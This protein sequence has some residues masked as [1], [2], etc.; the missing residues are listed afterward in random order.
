MAAIRAMDNE[1]SSSYLVIELSDGQQKRCPLTTDPCKAISELAIAKD[2]ILSITAKGKCS[3]E[4]CIFIN[5]ADYTQLEKLYFPQLES[6]GNIILGNTK[7][8]DLIGFPQ[9]KTM[10][11]LSVENCP[12][13][14]EISGFPQ[15]ETISYL[16]LENCPAL[17]DITGLNKLS[18]IKE[19]F[20]DH[21]SKLKQITGLQSL[22]KIHYIRKN[23][24][25]IVR[26][27]IIVRP[28]T[29]TSIQLVY[30]Y[31]HRINGLSHYASDINRLIASYSREFVPLIGLVE[32]LI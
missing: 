17:E 5:F 4:E 31:M 12:E 7:L 25:G 2:T 21:N 1:T 28:I 3:T 20:L 16:D 26:K 32:T 15:L 14:K 6:A 8:K 30:G 23:I 29:P 10:S 24:E 9:L 13:L 27:I 18:E 11:Y 19:L 22:K